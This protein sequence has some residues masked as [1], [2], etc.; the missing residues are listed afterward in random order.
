LLMRP[1]LTRPSF[2]VHYSGKSVLNGTDFVLRR[3]LVKLEDGLRA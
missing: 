3:A 1:S 2:R